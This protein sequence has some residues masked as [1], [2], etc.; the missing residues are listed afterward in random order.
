MHLLFGCA[1]PAPCD[2]VA[3]V[4]TFAVIGHNESPTLARALDQ[5]TAAAEDGDHLWFVD[6]ASTD[7][8]AHVARHAGAEVISAPLG[9]G[10]A[11]ATALKRCETPWF[12]YLDGDLHASERNLAVEL[13]AGIEQDGADLVLGEFV[14][15]GDSANLLT[16]AL[17]APIMSAL[18]PEAVGTFGAR[19]LTGFRA[20]RTDLEL[21]ALPPGFGVEMH[22]NLTALLLGAR[23]AVRQVGWFEHRY[24]S[25]PGVT[26]D[27]TAAMLDAAQRSGRLAPARRSAW[28]AWCSGVSD[29]YATW[30]NDPAERDAIDEQLRAVAARP[31][32]LA[33]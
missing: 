21:G 24:R 18:F 7:D 22:I 15:A 10:R 4:I 28:D 31:L 17:V 29:V 9:K 1:R 16:A 27:I 33:R 8:S 13:R 6:S 11:I 19:P 14:I 3:P 26:L 20:L 30:R 2:K 23:I 5:A 32:P 12:C 25:K